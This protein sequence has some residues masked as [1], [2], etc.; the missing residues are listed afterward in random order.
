[1]LT[2]SLYHV[3][4]HRRCHSH[5]PL[6]IIVVIIIVVTVIMITSTSIVIVVIIITSSSIV[7]VI[8]YRHRHRDGDGHGLGCGHSCVRGMD[9]CDPSRVPIWNTAPKT[10]MHPK[11][12][13]IVFT[14]TLRG[15]RLGQA[16]P[17]LARDDAEDNLW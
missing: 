17:R 3:L 16:W 2:S 15:S 4:S 14:W 13:P 12:S 10:S 11:V 7:V 8:V 9:V 5:R 1:M 6:V